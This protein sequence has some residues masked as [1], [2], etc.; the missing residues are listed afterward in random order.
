[1]KVQE[2]LDRRALD[3]VF[4]PIVDLETDAVFGY[5]ACGRTLPSAGVLPGP[6]EL[7]DH[8]HREGTLWALDLAWRRLAIE[9][10]ASWDPAGCSGVRW[11]L[12]HDARC[13]ADP[14]FDPRSTR[15][16]VEERGLGAAHVVVRIAEHDLDTELL[17]RLARD[18]RGQRFPVALDGFGAGYTPMSKLLAIAPAFLEIDHEIVRGA[19]LDPLR[20]AL[21]QV[22]VEVGARAP[23]TVIASGIETEA[24]LAALRRVGVRYGRG[25]LLGRPSALPLHSAA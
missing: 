17:A 18:L 22:V 7:L 24:D 8:A 23:F 9:R 6:A 19:S 14:G 21:A 11:F 16:L 4:Q 12:R 1:M 15:W 3:V 10:I 13:T 25:P 20:I 5:E 2:L